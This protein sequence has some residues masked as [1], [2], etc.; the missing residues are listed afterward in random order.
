MPKDEAEGVKQNACNLTTAQKESPM[1]TTKITL[2]IITLLLTTV[3]VAAQDRKKATEETDQYTVSAKP[4][5]IS[6]V[7][8]DVTLKRGEGQGETLL[9]GDELKPG[10]VIKTGAYGRAEILLNPGTYLRVDEN[11]ELV[12]TNLAAFRL[13]LKLLTGSAILEASAI[14]TAIQFAT[15]QYLFSIAQDGLYRFNATANNTSE[16][17][18][19]KGKVQVA[20]AIVKDGKKVV[21]SDALPMVQAFDKKAPDAFNAWSKDRAK[22][23]IAAN[24]KLS[25]RRMRTMPLGLQGNL[26]IYDPW[27]H[28]YTFLPGWG[29]F[30]SPYGGYYSNCHPSYRHSYNDYGNN[31]NWGNNG[32]GGSTSSG[33]GSMSSGS[34][35]TSSGSTGGA[36]TGGNR[37]GGFPGGDVSS[38]APR[39]DA[40]RTR[41]D[42]R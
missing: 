35:G 23:I 12:F 22:T 17:M 3:T 6:I 42:N 9:E 32:S 1:R 19:Y 34:G 8:G 27:Q 10:D 15:P 38:P 16:M 25:Q 24:K 18:V 31:N 29:G 40:G 37:V 2:F 39:M 36:H 30:S 28:R 5:I 20:G 14:D 33:G 21:V 13:K 26:W 7:S 11:T 4:G 41:K